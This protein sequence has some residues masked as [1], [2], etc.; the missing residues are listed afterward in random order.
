MYGLKILYIADLTGGEEINLIYGYVIYK[1]RSQTM[2]AEFIYS[3][4]AKA[5]K[6]QRANSKHPGIK[7]FANSGYELFV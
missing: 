1:L 4:A 5:T 7:A 6:M 2:V 3:E